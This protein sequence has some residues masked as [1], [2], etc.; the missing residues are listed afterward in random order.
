VGFRFQ[1]PPYVLSNSSHVHSNVLSTHSIPEAYGNRIIY[2]L[3]KQLR[4][5]F[6]KSCNIVG[7]LPQA[8]R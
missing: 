2:P 6:A 1:R 8:N 7:A 4:L 3:I 5:Q